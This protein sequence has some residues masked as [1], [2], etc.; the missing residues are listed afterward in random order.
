MSSEKPEFLPQDFAEIIAIPEIPFPE[1]EDE[2]L[3]LIGGQAVNLW[4]QIYAPTLPAL[5]AFTPYASIDADLFGSMGAASMLA[6]R[7]DWEFITFPD[8]DSFTGEP[9]PE[10]VRSAVLKK[11]TSGGDHLEVDILW[12]VP[13]LTFHEL[14]KPI[15]LEFEPNKYCLVAPPAVLLK[16][17]ITNLVEFS[18]YRGDGSRRNDLKHVQ[19]LSLICPH[20]I[21]AMTQGIGTGTITEQSVIDELAYLHSVVNSA[22]ASRAAIRFDVQLKQAFPKKLEGAEQHPNLSACLAKLTQRRCSSR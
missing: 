13:G 1:L 4:S 11:T 2:K 6:Q 16:A 7:H 21:Q 14:K 20:H 15:K 19:M 17:K 10:S 5:Q 8:K 22:D 3:I 18:G 9:N 12:D